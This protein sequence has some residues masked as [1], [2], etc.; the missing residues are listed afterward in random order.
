MIVAMS[1]YGWEVGVR[2]EAVL[3]IAVINEWRGPR[4]VRSSTR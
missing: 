3:P 4:T 2:F 1:H